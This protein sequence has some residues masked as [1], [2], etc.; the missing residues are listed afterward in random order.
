[1]SHAYNIVK[2][3]VFTLVNR[4]MEDLGVKGFT[5][6]KT[7]GLINLYNY[8][9]TFVNTEVWRHNIFNNDEIKIWLVLYMN[10]YIFRTV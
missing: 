2:F 9:I 10:I 4:F 8:D 5:Q 6:L 1:M 3:E 7:S